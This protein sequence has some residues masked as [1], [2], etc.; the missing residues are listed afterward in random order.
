MYKI[1]IQRIYPDCGYESTHY[2]TM[3]CLRVPGYGIIQI[4]LLN[5]RFS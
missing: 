4:N 1:I 5:G 2:K 3:A